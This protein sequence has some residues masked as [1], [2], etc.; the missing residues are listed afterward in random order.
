MNNHL[1]HSGL[2]IAVQDPFER[3]SSNSRP[4]PSSHSG[5][6]SAIAPGSYP[7]V[8]SGSAPSVPSGPYP[9]SVPDFHPHRSLWLTS[10]SAPQGTRW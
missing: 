8:S 6:T 4:V 9:S 10:D 7:T 1:C 5:F 2:L 3:T